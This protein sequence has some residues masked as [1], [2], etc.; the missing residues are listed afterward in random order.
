MG[1]NNLQLVAVF[2]TDNAFCELL[3]LM[4]YGAVLW[5]DRVPFSQDGVFSYCKLLN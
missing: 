5:R 2:G 1:A 3:S 4:H